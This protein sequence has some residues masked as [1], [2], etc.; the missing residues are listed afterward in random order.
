MPSRKLDWSPPVTSS[1]S[2]R[3]ASASS[4]SWVLIS[5][6]SARPI[7]PPIPVGSMLYSAGSTTVTRMTTA[8]VA[9]MIV[10]RISCAELG[11]SSR[12]GFSALNIF[13]SS[14]LCG[15]EVAGDLQSHEDEPH[16]HHDDV[17]GVGLAKEV[18][19]FPPVAHND[20]NHGERH[21]L[22]QFDADVERQEIGQQPV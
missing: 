13:L 17:G 15:N 14:S 18:R 21:D 8:L 10:E 16:G 12:L 1:S 4:A 3:S 7:A 2:N 9:A 5:P 20:E 19:G 11:S 22:A 6:I